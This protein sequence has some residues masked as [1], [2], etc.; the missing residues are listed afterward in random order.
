MEILWLL[1]ISFPIHTRNTWYAKHHD[2]DYPGWRLDPMNHRLRV[3]FRRSGTAPLWHDLLMS[4]R[5][6]VG[7]CYTNQS[8]AEIK[9]NFKSNWQ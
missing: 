3:L 5:A 2:L 7:Q 1:Y 9:R 6:P 8:G 4:L